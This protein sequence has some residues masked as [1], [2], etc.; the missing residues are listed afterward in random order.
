MRPRPLQ[1]SG[2]L[3]TAT[4]VF[5]ITTTLFSIVV[6]YFIYLFS[7]ERIAAGASRGW[8][9]LNFASKWYLYIV[10]GIF[11]LFAIIALVMIVAALIIWIGFF[12][13]KQQ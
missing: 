8:S 4:S 13:R 10:I 9:I 6:M 3:N 11:A 2:V 12:M 5:N 1:G 7:G